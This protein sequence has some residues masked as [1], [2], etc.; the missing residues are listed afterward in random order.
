MTESV[1]AGRGI[2]GLRQA[3]AGEVLVDGDPG[4]ADAGRVMMAAGR[5]QVIVRCA[6]ASD[7]VAALAY[8]ETLDLPIAVRSGGHHAAGFSTTDGGVLIDVRPMDEVRVL[9]DGV[10]RV[11]TGASWGEVAGR[12][13]K[14]G[15]AISSGDTASV[16]VGGLMAGGGIGWMVRKHGLAIDNVV[17]AEVVTADGAVRRVDAVSEPELFWGLRGAAGSLGVVT[18]YDIAAVHQPTVHYGTL[19][20]PWTQAEQ[21]LAGWAEYLAEAPEELTSSL[22][23]APTMMADRQVP[24]AV[25]VCVA[26]DAERRDAII[27]PL[28]HLGSL[29]TEK[30][31]E[32]PYAEVFSDMSMPADWRPR[33]RNGF[34]DEWST[35]VAGRLL[36][37]R[38]RIPGL[39]VEIRAL[40]GAFGAMPADGTAFA[41]RDA[42]F[43]VNSVLMGSPEQQGKQPKAFDNLWRSLKPDGAYLNFLSDPTDADL[44]VCYPASHRKRLAALKQSVDPG[45]VFRSALTV[46]PRPEWTGGRRHLMRWAMRS[47]R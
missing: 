35:D 4:Y 2:D 3:V 24:V 32:V 19:L 44:D 46:P 28:R 5:P 12:L 45:H 39:A 33:I 17:S 20:Y 47:R 37:A 41:H 18:S 15:L 9:P 42:R 23:L 43:M 22:Q 14:V 21:V 25:M 38:P 29:L 34:F 13:S 27:E 30:V 1:V 31:A 10:V 36:D 7:V 26:G 11:G 16:G 40:G 8:A 6:G